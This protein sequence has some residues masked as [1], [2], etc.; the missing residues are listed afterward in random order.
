MFVFIEFCHPRPPKH[1]LETFQEQVQ[2]RDIYFWWWWQ[3]HLHHNY[4]TVLIEKGSS[5]KSLMYE[6]TCLFTPHNNSTRQSGAQALKVALGPQPLVFIP[7]CNHH[8]LHLWVVGRT[9]DLLLLNGIQQWW[10]DNMCVITEHNSL[11]PWSLSLPGWFW[12]SKWPLVG[13]W[14]TRKW[15]L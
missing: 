2:G 3:H 14:P 1:C 4:L 15:G 6:L 10:C 5:A 11:I 8:P 12:E 7:L 9:W 13:K